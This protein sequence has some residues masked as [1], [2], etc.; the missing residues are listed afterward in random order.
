MSQPNKKKP[1]N[2]SPNEAEGAN[3]KSETKRGHV[4]KYKHVSK[5]EPSFTIQGLA[6]LGFWT[7]KKKKSGERKKHRNQSVHNNKQVRDERDAL[8]PTLKIE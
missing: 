2:Q 7:E 5:T 6:V 1:R 8:Y 4:Y 3:C